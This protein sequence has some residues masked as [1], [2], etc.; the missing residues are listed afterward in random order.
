MGMF[1]KKVHH[2]F[3]IIFVL[4]TLYGLFEFN[5]SIMDLPMPL[6]TICMHLLGNILGGN[7]LMFYLSLIVIVII[8]VLVASVLFH[9]CSLKQLLN[10]TLQVICFSDIILVVFSLCLNDT[11]DAIQAFL[12]I[13]IDLLYMGIIGVVMFLDKETQGNDS[14]T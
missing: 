11:F 7:K 10:Y 14:S 13:I 6:K 1:Y 9:A 2:C 3:K 12:C 5:F 4:F 8:I